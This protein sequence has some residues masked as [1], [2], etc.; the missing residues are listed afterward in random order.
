MPNLP[1]HDETC[2]SFPARHRSKGPCAWLTSKAGRIAKRLHKKAAAAGNDHQTP[3]VS[4]L[5]PAQKRRRFRSPGCQNCKGSKGCK[6]FLAYLTQANQNEKTPPHTIK[7]PK[8]L[9]MRATSVF[10]R[11][12]ALQNACRQ[13]L[14]YCASRLDRSD[15]STAF[16]SAR[17]LPSSKTETSPQENA[18]NQDLI[19]NNPKTSPPE[20][21]MATNRP[22]PTPPG[23]GGRGDHCRQSAARPGSF[24]PDSGDPVPKQRN[25]PWRYRIL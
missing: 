6:V 4:G 17:P 18:P 20:G 15:P 1:S 9:L 24:A 14:R 3:T 8:A 5:P 7:E 16:A 10:Q 21:G 25:Q 2:A 19:P 22:S 23:T 12:S 11:V 13:E